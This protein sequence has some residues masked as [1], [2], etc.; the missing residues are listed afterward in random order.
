MYANL[1][2]AT[3]CKEGSCALQRVGPSA[4]MAVARATDGRASWRH[5]VARHP[6]AVWPKWCR[7]SARSDDFSG[8]ETHCRRKQAAPQQTP[9][10]P[11][12]TEV[13]PFPSVSPVAVKSEAGDAAPP[14]LD[15]PP[16]LRDSWLCRRVHAD[17]RRRCTLS[18][19]ARPVRCAC[20]LR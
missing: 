9:Q 16:D 20:Y 19:N 11:D 17:L 2:I 3:S 6:S 12:A 10:A 18:R 4:M 7:A 1:N 8:I 15:R 13:N 14:I 5:G